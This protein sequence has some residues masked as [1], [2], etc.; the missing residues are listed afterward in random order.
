MSGQV[1]FHQ[2]SS[3]DLLMDQS[4]RTLLLYARSCPDQ[5]GDVVA[6]AKC[7]IADIIAAARPYHYTARLLSSDKG[8]IG[9]CQ[10]VVSLAHRAGDLELIESVTPFLDGV[11]AS[12]Q[13]QVT[14]HSDE[15]GPDIEK[16]ISLLLTKLSAASAALENF[17]KSGEGAPR[18]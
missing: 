12:Q 11:T 6:Q 8:W 1:R 16:H 10:A 9:L 17:N 18:M 3:I 14:T 2:L 13:D 15:A 5:L 4:R 7:Y